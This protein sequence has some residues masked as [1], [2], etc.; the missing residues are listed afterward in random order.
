MYTGQRLT[1][2]AT[3]VGATLPATPTGYIAPKD[4]STIQIVYEK[5][6]ETCD[7]IND[8]LEAAGRNGVI[9]QRNTDELFRC[10]RLGNDVYMAG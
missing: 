8:D 6:K 9:V 2:Y 3:G 1:V 4:D 7:E 5:T 10:M